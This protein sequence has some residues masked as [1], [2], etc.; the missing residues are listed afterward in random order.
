MYLCKI[1]DYSKTY[2]KVIKCK[3][4]WGDSSPEIIFVY[5]NL[6][7]YS[8]IRIAT[9]HWNSKTSSTITGATKIWNRPGLENE[10]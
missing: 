8:N 5:L 4:V 1:A 2:L 3:A 10:F 7:Q 6:R 9:F